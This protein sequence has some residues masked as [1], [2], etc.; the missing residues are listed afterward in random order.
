M[1]KVIGLINTRSI[2]YF[3]GGGKKSKVAAESHSSDDLPLILNDNLRFD[4]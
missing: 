2:R 1:K 3:F 4:A